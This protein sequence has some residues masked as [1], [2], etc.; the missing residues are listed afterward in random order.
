VIRSTPNRYGAYADTPHPGGPLPP[1][2]RERLIL[3]YSPLI[4]YI[5]GRIAMRLP[6]HLSLD[7]L[8]SAGILGLIDAVDKYDSSRKAKFKTYAEYRIRGAIIDELRAMDWVPR[9]VRRK[10]QQLETAFQTLTNDLGREPHD[11]E[12]AEY[13]AID[14]ESYYTMV[15]ETAGV[16]LFSIV[17]TAE[18]LA[19]FMPGTLVD[20]ALKDDAD[21]PA[22]H[23]DKNEI[24]EVI[25]RAIEKL[26]EQEQMVISLYYYD[27]LTMKETGKV[28]DY[29][30]SR[31][32]QIHSKAMMKLR[33]KLRR[34]FEDSV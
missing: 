14:L 12:V 9:S 10:A 19:Q 16:G 20:N 3:D 13:L 7:D 4:R 6:A 2:E 34:Y 22:E 21:S 27:E 15:N 8:I 11:E 29:T 1:E 17:D 33:A 25:A 5:A 24:K 23:L 31:I 30:E 28:L 18:G 26:T 32:C